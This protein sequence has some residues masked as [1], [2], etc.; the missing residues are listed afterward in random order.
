[1]GELIFLTR[2]KL[3][4]S[5]E[6]KN[7]MIAELSLRASSGKDT[8]SVF[9]GAKQMERIIDNNGSVHIWTGG[10]YYYFNATLKH[11]SNS[12]DLTKEKVESIYQQLSEIAVRNYDITNLKLTA[13]VE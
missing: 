4:D 7:N 12:K 10:D 6:E 8:D 1:M 2:E 13:C 11:E 5:G 9:E 3:D